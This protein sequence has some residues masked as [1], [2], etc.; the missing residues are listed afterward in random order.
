DASRG[1]VDAADGTED[2]GFSSTNPAHGVNVSGAAPDLG[3]WGHFPAGSIS[4]VCHG[5]QCWVSLPLSRERWSFCVS[6]APRCGW[7]INKPE[8]K[9]PMADDAGPLE[10]HVLFYG[11]IISFQVE[12][13][14]FLACPSFYNEAIEEQ[15]APR[16]HLRSAK[17]VAP[18]PA[19]VA[20]LP[21]PPPPPSSLLQQQALEVQQQQAA[22]AGAIAARGFFFPTSAG[23]PR[24]SLADVV[25]AVVGGAGNGAAPPPPALPPKD[26]MTRCAFQL[27]PDQAVSGA[28]SAPVTY[29]SIVRVMHYKTAYR[30]IA[31]DVQVAGARTGECRALLKR[32]A[33]EDDRSASLFYIMPRFSMRVEGEM[34]RTNDP[35]VF[36]S[37]QFKGRQLCGPGA[38]TSLLPRAAAAAGLAFG[39][40]SGGDGGGGG[41]AGGG[42]FAVAAA[43]RAAAAAEAAG[44]WSEQEAMVYTSDCAYQRRGW[45]VL[46]LC[47]RKPPI[48]GVP[49]AAGGPG[50]GGPAAAGAAGAGGS[51][52]SGAAVSSGGEPTAAV[53]ARNSVYGGDFVRFLHLQEGGYLLARIDDEAERLSRVSPFSL[54]CKKR[55]RRLSR[56]V[57]PFVRAGTASAKGKGGAGGTGGGG[58]GGAKGGGSGGSGNCAE[59]AAAAASASIWQIENEKPE[60]G[61]DVEWMRGIRLRH[62][63]TGQYLCIREVAPADAPLLQRLAVVAG[64]ADRCGGDGGGGG[65]AG[66]GGGGAGLPESFHGAGSAHGGGGTGIS[67]SAHGAGAGG[68]DGGGGGSGAADGRESSPVRSAAATI[69]ARGR[70]AL[71]E[72]SEDSPVAFVAGSG[73]WPEPRGPLA[74]RAAARAAGRS[75]SPPTAAVRGSSSPPAA[76]RGSSPPPVLKAASPPSLRPQRPSLL[77]SIEEHFFRA[78]KDG[79]RAGAVPTAAPRGGAGGVAETPPPPPLLPPP[80]SGAASTPQDMSPEHSPARPR[81]PEGAAARLTE[82]RARLV[83]ATTS[84]RADPTTLFDVLPTVSEDMEGGSGGGGGGGG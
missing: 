36:E 49:G 20:N 7:D 62:L 52:A 28:G 3:K 56:V 68:G 10:H 45:R 57:V 66:D 73:Q 75:A 50:V 72:V 37:V 51:G 39:R 40:S 43:M 42:L 1:V 59:E 74:A 71:A 8:A 24:R 32:A 79:V 17:L 69:A 4:R 38:A 9:G 25:S 21:P 12:G 80:S 77:D 61:S 2:E 53:L 60:D 22:A 15:T 6:G 48:S 26:F 5:I 70:A 65:G 35:V 23:G 44:E 76:A 55:S 46:R 81:T 27:L 67:G 30:I 83:V 84:L 14:G 41:L 54:V 63:V 78:P 13:D 64:G 16:T 31:S 47:E 18:L 11:D 33:S 34:V 29:G 19:S 58:G 82:R